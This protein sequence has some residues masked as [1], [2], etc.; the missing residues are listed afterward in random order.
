[1]LADTPPAKAIVFTFVCSIA[2]LVFSINISV[3]VF[4]KLAHKSALFMSGVLWFKFITA[5]FIPLKLKSK[6]SKC[7]LGKFIFAC[8]SFA[9]LSTL[10]PSWIS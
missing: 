2:F 7:V 4:S 10:G 5:V 1:M 8:P 6:F 9:S 3:I